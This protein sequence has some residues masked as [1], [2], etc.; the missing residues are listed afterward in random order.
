LQT[1]KEIVMKR[2]LFFAICVLPLWAG[3]AQA[4][5]RFPAQPIS[6]L[7]FI[8]QVQVAVEERLRPETLPGLGHGFLL[9]LPFTAEQS[10][11][12]A[13][14]DDFPAAGFF[15]LDPKKDL[16]PDLSLFP[17][18]R[19]TKPEEESDPDRRALL[20]TMVAFQDKADS[21][22][23]DLETLDLRIKLWRERKEEGERITA[24][25]LHTLDAAIKDLLPGLFTARSAT[26][27]L[28]KN[29]GLQLQEAE[30]ALRDY[31]QKHTHQM[32]FLPSEV[33]G[34][35]TVLLR[36][37]YIL[38]G[39][40]RIAYDLNA[41]PA[42]DSLTISQSA[43]LVQS[44]GFSWKDVDVLI[45]T[46][47]R[48][49]DLDPRSLFP[50]KIRLD[51]AAP[52]S[53]SPLP[54]QLR[55]QQVSERNRTLAAPA[56]GE[57]TEESEEKSVFRLWSLGKRS[58]DTDVVATVPFAFDKYPARFHY[59]LRPSRSPKGVLS[60]VLALDQ[61]V[62][63][64]AGQ[65]RFFV[66]AVFVGDKL[67]S[68]NGREA[69]LHFGSDPQI[70]VTRVDRKRAS[71]E[72]GF[73]S[74]EQTVFWHWDFIVSNSRNRPVE[75]WIEDP[76]PDALDN[77]I[78]V[79]VVSTPRPEEEILDL[80]QGGAKI[81]RWKLSLAPGEVRTITHKVTVSAP[82]DKLLDPGRDMPL[83]LK[84]DR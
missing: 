75:T 7:F 74:K 18:I 70:A 1:I 60:A 55:A 22:D 51:A 42:E 21:L 58:L 5:L 41:L 38:P 44:S 43:S 46:A 77:A 78:T 3:T 12:A 6:A 59:T 33:P 80:R 10:S 11:F 40:C 27:R 61:A 31:D 57:F 28:R 17:R 63:L 36:Y 9:V 73:L 14:A 67:L 39:S 34:D 54:Q 26:E 29:N 35:K 66:D 71:G 2:I 81:Y 82:S 64:P 79:N 8:D 69:V 65:A 68:L 62:E 19:A 72:Q 56:N 84:Q 16:P 23:A 30:N 76:L 47:G 13:T 32:L 20:R 83:P 52:T 50:W 49:I 24:E 4:A 48:D 45:S 25:D 37:T 15:W 53:P